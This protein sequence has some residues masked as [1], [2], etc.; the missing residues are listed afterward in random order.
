MKTREL[1]RQTPTRRASL[2]TSRFLLQLGTQR[3]DCETLINPSGNGQTPNLYP[4]VP[5]FP[6]ENRDCWRGNKK[7]RAGRIRF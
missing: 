7:R 3:R 2:Q 1:E 5:L 6:A 4:V